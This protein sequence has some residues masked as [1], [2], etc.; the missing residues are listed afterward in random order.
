MLQRKLKRN[1]KSALEIIY[2]KVEPEFRTF[3]FNPFLKKEINLE[4]NIRFS[5]R[6]ELRKWFYK[7]YEIFKKQINYKI[8]NEFKGFYTHLLN[9]YESRRSYYLW[10]TSL[11]TYLEYITYSLE[12]LADEV[13]S[14]KEPKFPPN[15]S[16][17]AYINQKLID[18]IE[19]WEPWVRWYKQN[20]KK[21]LRRQGLNINPNPDLPTLQFLDNE[22]IDI[23]NESN[24][25]KLLFL[26]MSKPNTLVEYKEIAREL[27]FNWFYHEIQNDEAGYKLRFIKKRLIHLL[28]KTKMAKS[29]AKKMI[30]TRRGKGLIYIPHQ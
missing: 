10:V 8:A 23:S 11:K 14:D 29:Q 28:I 20:I 18:S 21:E 9:E 24:V 6:R 5:L 26:L 15:H 12:N 30:Q 2:K 22:P 19:Q 27:S 7:T 1:A 16:E 17:S 13:F 3:I 4:S 25:V